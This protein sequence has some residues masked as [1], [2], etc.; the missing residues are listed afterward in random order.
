[1]KAT[2]QRSIDNPEASH[3]AVCK[4][5]DRHNAAGRC[6]RD[7]AEHQVNMAEVSTGPHGHT[8]GPELMMGVATSKCRSGRLPAA[9]APLVAATSTSLKPAKP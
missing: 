5:S 6:W 4:G 8:C 3:R 9:M 2:T 7:M 1:M